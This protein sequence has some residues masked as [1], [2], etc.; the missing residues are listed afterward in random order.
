MGLEEAQL[1]L[2]SYRTK[3]ASGLVKGILAYKNEYERT[4]GFSR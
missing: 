1:R 2:S 3:I 4:N